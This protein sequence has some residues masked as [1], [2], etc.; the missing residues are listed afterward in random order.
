MFV[1]IRFASFYWYTKQFNICQSLQRMYYVRPRLAC[2]SVHLSYTTRYFLFAK[3]LQE[4]FL[5]YKYKYSYLKPECEESLAYGRSEAEKQ[6]HFESNDRKCTNN[7]T[8]NC[9]QDPI[10][11]VEKQVLY[12]SVCVRVALLVQHATRTRHIVTSFVAPLAPPQFSTLSHKGD[13]C[14]KNVTEHKMC[15]L[16]FKFD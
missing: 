2:T 11:A 14:R 4:I 1:D 10:V 9:V 8:I 12:I 6:M 16:I 13:D 15:V 5:W 3:L 7:A